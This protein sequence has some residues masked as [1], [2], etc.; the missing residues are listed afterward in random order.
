MRRP[1]TVG[2]LLSVPL[3]W[4]PNTSGAQRAAYLAAL[5]LVAI[6]VSIGIIMKAAQRGG[7]YSFST[8]GSV[9]ISEFLK[10]LLSTVF[11]YRDC[12]RRAAEGICPS[13]R[14]CSA[15]YTSLPING[16]AEGTPSAATPIRLNIRLFWTY[17]RGEVT[18]DVRFGF[19]N[20]ALFYVLI[21]NSVFTS[22]LNLD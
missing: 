8:S 18:K 1:T 14:G 9:A 22:R 19:C 6:Q 7:S 2:N 21:N 5:G 3:S 16:D 10:M 13:T 11:F 15:G 20:L 12:K 4:V 17:I